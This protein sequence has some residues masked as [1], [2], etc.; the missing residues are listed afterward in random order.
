[1]SH[2][3]SI[4]PLQQQRRQVKMVCQAGWL[5]GRQEATREIINFS[6][7]SSTATEFPSEW[8]KKNI[9]CELFH[10]FSWSS[11]LFALLDRD[12]SRAREYVVLFYV[13]YMQVF[14]FLSTNNR[15][16]V[17]IISNQLHA[18][19]TQQWTEYNS[20]NNYQDIIVSFVPV[21]DYDDDFRNCNNRA[22]RGGAAGPRPQWHH[23]GNVKLNNSDSECIR[24]KV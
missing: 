8:P 6:V 11:K 21:T 4:H 9:M 18:G 10:C 16:I 5:A 20:D 24:M 13:Q 22:N 12:R 3:P 2:P 17:E 7:V 1:M 19:E 15:S 14:V 23:C